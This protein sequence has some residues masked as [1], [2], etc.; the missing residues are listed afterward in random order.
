[1]VISEHRDLRVIVP[2]VLDVWSTRSS[3]LVELGERY[4]VQINF[5]IKC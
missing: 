1:M 2:I 3:W 5:V 4:R